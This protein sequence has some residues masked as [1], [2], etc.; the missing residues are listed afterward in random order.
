MDNEKSYI[1]DVVAGFLAIPI[2]LLVV[3]AAEAYVWG[4]LCILFGLGCITKPIWAADKKTDNK[5]DTN[6]VRITTAIQATEIQNLTIEDILDI[7]S[8][9]G[10]IKAVVKEINKDSFHENAA[11]FGRSFHTGEWFIEK[12]I[13]IISFSNN[14][15]LVY[16]SPKRGILN[17]NFAPRIFLKDTAPGQLLFELNTNEDY[18]E[19]F[20]KPIREEQQEK[21]REAKQRE[22]EYEK[23]QIAEKLRERE[24]RRKLEKQVLQELIDDGEILPAAGRAP[25]PRDI[26]DAVYTRD[27]GRCVYCGS[28]ENLQIDHIIPFSKGG[29][30]TLENFQ[31][32]CQ[33]CNVDKSNKIG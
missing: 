9:N 17:I 20:L 25:I 8:Q 7:S 29:A 13:N 23:R 14:K 28:T 31:I 10:I 19:L 15:D 1:G 24:R 32:L 11:I 22:A 26:V 12:G 21:E 2:G 16:T 33:K 27:G 4:V 18:I 3:F 6:N 5:A 30:D